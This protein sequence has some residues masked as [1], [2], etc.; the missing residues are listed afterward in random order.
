MSDAAIEPAAF[1]PDAGDLS[2]RCGDE[3][4]AV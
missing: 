3:G 2:A 1:W 4:V